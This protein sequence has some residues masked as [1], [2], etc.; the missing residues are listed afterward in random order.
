MNISKETLGLAGE[1]A[2]ASEL[3]RRGIYTQLTL[4]NKKRTDLLVEKKGIFIG[5]EVKSKQTNKGWPAIKGISEGQSLL[6][7]VDFFC[8]AE[9][10]RPDF[11]ILTAKEWRKIALKRARQNPTLSVGRDNVPRWEDESSWVGIQ[12]K[13][14]EL[15][16]HLE[17]WEKFI[18]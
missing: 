10:V 7:F 11:Y 16:E 1:Y 9:T 12:I 17:K 8:K 15:Q 2:V 13:A 14:D 5:V 18:S 3:C 4:G 6:V